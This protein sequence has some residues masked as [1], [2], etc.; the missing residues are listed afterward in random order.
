MNLIPVN[1]LC[2]PCSMTLQDYY[3]LHM[4][5]EATVTT[6]EQRDSP[7]SIYFSGLQTHIQGYVLQMC[8]D[9]YKGEHNEK[10]NK[11]QKKST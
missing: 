1:I 8:N 3:I 9:S 10:C 5:C 2:V 7:F 4:Q 6:V 11:R